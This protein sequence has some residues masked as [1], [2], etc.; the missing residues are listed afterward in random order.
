MEG[1]KSNFKYRKFYYNSTSQYLFGLCIKSAIPTNYIPDYKISFKEDRRTVVIYTFH[2]V[3]ENVR[4]FLKHGLFKSNLIDF[5]VV[6][7]GNHQLEVP[8]YVTYLNRE[9]VGHDFG[10]WSYAI[11]QLN[12]REKYQ[13][14]VCIN[15]SV[16]GPFIPPW[17]PIK[18]WVWIFTRL[19]DY[20]TKLVG[21]SIGSHKYRLHIQSMVL[22]FDQIGLDIGLRLGIFEKNPVA[23]ERW[24]VIEQ[25]EIGFSQAIL[26]SGYRVR[27]IISAY[28]N[29][30]ITAQDVIPN[31][32]HL[33][34]NSY[35]GTN[36]HPYEL[37]FIKDKE[38][39]NT[40]TE[41]HQKN[42][43]RLSDPL[44]IAI[45]TH[46]PPPIPPQSAPGQKFDRP[47]VP[48]DFDW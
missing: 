30:N 16:R 10:G 37:I 48:A 34:N 21:T 36:L 47:V 7:N 27:P 20:R 41:N 40:Y 43:D 38:G 35:Y 8:S 9:N 18:N 23:R 13:F 28:Y 29:A 2:E 32:I 14:F 39:I 24:D 1:F 44:P 4:F 3:N 12:L 42:F 11:H 46:I 19:L 31:R 26:T 6:C 17:S 25:K 45:P 33:T 5:V 15:S 22:V